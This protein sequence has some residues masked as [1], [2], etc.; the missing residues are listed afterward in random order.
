M[1]KKITGT[2]WLPDNPEKKHY[3]ILKIYYSKRSTLELKGLFVKLKDN[4]KFINPKFILGEGEEVGRITLFQ[5]SEYDFSREYSTFHVDTIFIGFHFTKEEQLKFLNISVEY[6]FL[7][8]WIN[9]VNTFKPNFI[10][11]NKLRI[12][13]KPLRSKIIFLQK[14]NLKLKLQIETTLSGQMSFMPGCQFDY[15]EITLMN[16]KSTT[17]RP[18]QFEDLK[19]IILSMQDFFSFIFQKPSYPISIFGKR[20]INKNTLLNPSIQ[21]YFPLRGEPNIEQEY[22]FRSVLFSFRDVSDKFGSIIKK[23]FENEDRL[24]SIY[25]LY[26]ASLYNYEMY[27]EYEFLS[28]VQAIEAFHRIKYSNNSKYMS[29]GEYEIILD[30]LKNV[31]I[32]FIEKPFRDILFDKLRYGNEYSLRQ[33]FKELFRDIFLKIFKTSKPKLKRFIGKVIDTRNYLIHQDSSMESIA[34]N[35]NEFFNA[36]TILKTLIEVHLLNE[37]GIEVE[38]IQKYYH[39]KIKHNNLTLKF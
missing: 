33:R 37:L 15:K 28:L 32:Q 34:F 8:N 7:T 36:N 2:W 29:D 12:S 23:W 18:Y 21:I 10:K 5:A 39:K 19:N 30:K 35:D 1:I 11:E 17:K 16:L 14:N 3:G 13:Y 24:I 38:E 6:L 31:S 22:N 20:N 9:P 25:K 26:L 4:F 27:L